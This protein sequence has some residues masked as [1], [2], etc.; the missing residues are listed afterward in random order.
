MCDGIRPRDDARPGKFVYCKCGA[1]RY[2][3]AEWKSQAKR[4]DTY[5]TYDSQYCNQCGVMMRD[6][7]WWDRHGID[8][9][10]P[11]IYFKY[12]IKKYIKGV[13][14]DLKTWF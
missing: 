4:T 6:F 10:K 9:T 2:I 8:P 3:T 13:E 5:Y 11:S 1:K 12:L 7:L 14:F